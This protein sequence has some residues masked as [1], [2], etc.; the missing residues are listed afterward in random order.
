MNQLEVRER[1]D[2][3]GKHRHNHPSRRQWIR[4]QDRIM[5]HEKTFRLPHRLMKPVLEV[6]GRINRTDHQELT[7]EDQ[8]WIESHASIRDNIPTSEEIILFHQAQPIPPLN[9]GYFS[10][11]AVE[12]RQIARIREDIRRE[13]K[14]PDSI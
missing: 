7:P 11:E 3:W 8:E 5:D 9:T 13:N 2:S 10:E 1:K 4:E 12:Q 14:P 6:L